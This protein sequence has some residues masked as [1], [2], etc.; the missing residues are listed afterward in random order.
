MTM[1]A[2]LALILSLVP[3]DLE[4]L[5]RRLAEDN[6]NVR[7]ESTRELER[8]GLGALPALKKALLGNDPEV[9]T[10]AR[11]LIRRIERAE[12]LRLAIPPPKRVTLNLKNVTL[13]D[14]LERIEKKTGYD[15]EAIGAVAQRRIGDLELQ[16]ATFWEAVLTVMRRV[17]GTGHVDVEGDRLLLAE[18][19]GGT[20][21]TE[22]PLLAWVGT[23]GS[24]AFAVGF[25]VEPA[26]KAAVGL[27]SSV[28][29]A[30]DE[31]GKIVGNLIG[32][33][34]FHDFKY[35]G[36]THFGI[37]PPPQL[38][39]IRVSAKLYYALEEKTVRLKPEDNEKQIEVDGLSISYVREGKARGS[40]TLVLTLTP[41][42]SDKRVHTM[43]NVRRATWVKAFD[44]AKNPLPL[45]TSS[46][47]R[48]APKG[49][50]FRFTFGDRTGKK[51]FLLEELAEVEVTFVTEAVERD[52]EFVFEDIHL[53][54]E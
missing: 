20:A 10:R 40:P 12:K 29:E 54:K 17:A 31:K 8:R 47:G 48:R 36:Q 5:I 2:A 26:Q 16:D 7:G 49:A 32:L 4:E 15:M 52:Y 35:N 41:L 27:R 11:E 43:I 30:L 18:G 46:G 34:D 38:S 44:K 9:S 21:K 24:G 25:R 45:F 3:Q 51:E 33:G 37:K 13:R 28:A 42:K 19:V 14:A 6:L 22:G 23:S 50:S 39:R 1:V 53:G